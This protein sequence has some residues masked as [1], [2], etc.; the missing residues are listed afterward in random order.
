MFDVAVLPV[1][2]ALYRQEWMW[3]A[4]W[5]PRGPALF[6]WSDPAAPGTGAP[7][8]SP[9]RRSHHSAFW[10]DCSDPGGRN[11]NTVTEKAKIWIITIKK[12]MYWVYG[13]NYQGLTF[14]ALSP[15]FFCCCRS[16]SS[17]S[18]WSFACCKSASSCSFLSRAR[19][20][21]WA[22]STLAWCSPWRWASSV[23]FSINTFWC[24]ST[25]CVIHARKCL[26]LQKLKWIY[27]NEMVIKKY[28]SCYTVRFSTYK[29]CCYLV[30][31]QLGFMC[32]FSRLSQSIVPVLNLMTQLC[33]L[34]N[35]HKWR[36]TDRLV[37]EYCITQNTERTDM[38]S[39]SQW[40]TVMVPNKDKMCSVKNESHLFLLFSEDLSEPLD[41]FVS[42]QSIF[43]LRAEFILLLIQLHQQVLLA[44]K[45]G[46]YTMKHSKPDTNIWKSK[47]S[48][49][50]TLFWFW[51]SSSVLVRDSLV[52]FVRVSS[53]VSSLLQDSNRLI[54]LCF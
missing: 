14:R 27:I 11:D 40:T 52:L 13:W 46:S 22:S 31:L 42:L 43:L 24:S 54:S 33:N 39:L 21:F 5:S 8:H 3:A 50:C 7:E 30:F 23:C 36:M 32:C 47:M 6:F 26:S 45:K 25:P 2:A 29:R 37:L 28:R 15:F 38:W 19:C 34:C 1:A 41:C 53:S 51:V 35:T 9:C 49:L 44:W 20:S 4:G 10:S 18:S 48:S 12:K 16:S 17:T